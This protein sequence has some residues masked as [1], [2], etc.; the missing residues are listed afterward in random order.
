LYFVLPI[1]AVFAMFYRGCAN[2]AILHP[3]AR[4]ISVRIAEQKLIPVSVGGKVEVWRAR[5]LACRGREPEAYVLRFCGN[6]E[7][8]E[9]ALQNELIR[10]SPRPVE[11]WAENHPGY[12]GSTTHCNLE[13]LAP[14]ALA[15]FDDLKQHSNGKPIF[16]AGHSLGTTELLY[17]SAH[18]AIAGA[19]IHDPPPL[20]ELIVGR[21][22]W[23]NLWV[24]AYGVAREIPPN[25]D[26]MANAKQTKAPA[27]FVTGECAGVIPPRFQRM[28]YDAYAG[29]KRRVIQKGCGHNDPIEG[30]AETELQLGIEWL[31][32][33]AIPSDGAVSPSVSLQR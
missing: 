23:W 26:S 5:T 9:Y 21:W 22:G 8:A 3:N 31:W 7:R 2:W 33:M 30:E 20:R 15:A 27:V 24:L 4:P 18:R 29:P 32:S 13:N 16:L 19:I 10:W 12:G 1:V 28:V 14:A 17:V 25:L 6:G 11:I